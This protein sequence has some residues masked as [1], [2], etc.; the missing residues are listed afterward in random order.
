M[1]RRR[2][3]PFR[4]HK[5]TFR[6]LTLEEALQFCVSKRLLSETESDL[7]D[8]EEATASGQDGHDAGNNAQTGGSETS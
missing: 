6:Q 3:P 1:P 2:R 4:G 7:S 5:D 8:E